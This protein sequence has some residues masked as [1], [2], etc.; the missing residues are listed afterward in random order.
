MPGVPDVVTA[1]VVASC[2]VR[3]PAVDV[4]AAVFSVVA[5]AVVA[6]VVARVVVVTTAGVRQDKG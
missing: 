4:T 3:V 2:V 1:V 6:V 5:A